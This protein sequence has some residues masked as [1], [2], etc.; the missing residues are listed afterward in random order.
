MNKRKDRVGMKLFVLI[1]ILYGFLSVALGAFGAHALEGKVSENA[2]SIWDKAV[3][4]QMFH[5][6]SIIIAGFALIKFESG[7]LLFAGWAF[8]IGVLLFSGSLYVYATTGI[9]MMAMITPFGGVFFL[10]GWVLFG[11]AMMKVL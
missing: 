6:L 1:G 7:T 4:Y 5:A 9:R 8:I 2:L 3:H 10:L 11:Y